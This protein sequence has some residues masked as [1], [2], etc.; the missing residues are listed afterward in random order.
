M[1]KRLIWMYIFWVI[2]IITQASRNHP[3]NTYTWPNIFLRWNECTITQWV[4]S[5]LATHVI[6]Q[7]FSLLWTNLLTVYFVQSDH[8]LFGHVLLTMFCWPLVFVPDH[9]FSITDHVLLTMFLLSLTILFSSLTIFFCKWLLCFRKWLIFLNDH[10][11]FEN[12]SSKY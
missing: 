12:D 7:V 8:S 10:F 6:F 2:N 11:V 1:T 3:T 4:V 9:S 5:R